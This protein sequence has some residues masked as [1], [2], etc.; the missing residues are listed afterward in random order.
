M[1]LQLKFKLRFKQQVLLVSA[2][3]VLITAA[4]GAGGFYT[5]SKQANLAREIYDK[6]FM[7]V[8]YARKSQL[9]WR[10]YLTLAAQ[11]GADEDEK[12][13]KLSTL[14]DELGV[15][16]E[17]AITEKAKKASLDLQGRIKT[18]QNNTGATDPAEAEATS[19]ALDKMVQRFMNDGSNY[20]DQVD[21]IVIRAKWLLGLVDGVALMVAFFIGWML[22][23]AALQQEAAAANEHYTKSMEM[24]ISR[25]ETSST[26]LVASA[27]Q[28]GAALEASAQQMA[29]NAGDTAQQ[30]AQMA[31]ST[32]QSSTNL[33]M[34]A[35]AAE[36]M[37]S[38]SSEIQHLVM[39]ALDIS[40]IS[41][42]LMHEADGTVGALAGASQSVAGVVGV[43]SD[44]AG[45]T[46]LLALN[47][48][49]EAARAGEAGKGFA[50]VAAEVKALADQT[51]DSTTKI[52]KQIQDMQ[53]S[54]E[55][56]IDAL[57]QIKH[58][59]DEN[60]RLIDA[61]TH[62]ITEQGE[63]TTEITRNVQ[64][65]ADGSGRITESVE[66]V[67]ETATKSGQSA[68]KM[69]ADIR[70]LQ[71]QLDKLQKNIHTFLEGIL[72]L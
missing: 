33:H 12:K 63:A 10:L 34:V 44:L 41:T 5:S 51:T 16:A 72:A 59:I 7:G 58:Q 65:V 6:A 68:Q 3:S 42:R 66:R 70:D 52:D 11:S 50:V 25:F 13:A 36:E 43:I 47:A 27:A 64:Q 20:R 9:D 46:N 62:A 26:A 54:S 31:D 49:I 53:F 2:V 40:Q 4:L 60:Q 23:R 71:L 67:S 14:Y 32:R 45:Q 38:S 17:R 35:A 61:V 56:T 57:R 69:L 22:R 8:N 39:K 30:V 18:L 19:V 37:S 29:V 24:L 21:D 48:T 28:A 55:R 1:A 15:A